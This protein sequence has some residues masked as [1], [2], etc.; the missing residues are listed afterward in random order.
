VVVDLLTIQLP[1]D[2]LANLCL[3]ALTTLQWHLKHLRKSF[4]CHYC[5][6]LC[7]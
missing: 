5:K 7:W 3:V 6:Q 4:K 2:K 1:G